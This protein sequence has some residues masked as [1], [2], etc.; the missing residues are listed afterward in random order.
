M[1]AVCEH[2]PGHGSGLRG[3]TL[4]WVHFEALLPGILVLLL[5]SKVG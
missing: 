5:G 3:A 4:W 2:G 1:V